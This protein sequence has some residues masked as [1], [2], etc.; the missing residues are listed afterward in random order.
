MC[1][2]IIAVFSL[3]DWKRRW[4]LPLTTL[5]VYGG[6]SLAF[7]LSSNG[8]YAYYCYDLLL[9]QQDNWMGYT[10]FDFVKD[11]VLP[12]LS[13]AALFSLFVFL[14]WS[15]RES[16]ERLF[17]WLIIFAST[18]ITSYVGKSKVGGVN[19]VVIPTFAIFSLFLGIGVPEILKVFQTLPKRSH[20]F[21]EICL[22]LLVFFQLVQVIY[23]PIL[24][25][26]PLADYMDGVK[27]LKF[28]KKFDGNVYVPNSSILLMAGKQTFAH[29]YAIWEIVHSHGKSKEKE[30]FEIDLQR[31]IDMHLFD[32]IVVLP[33]L[34]YFPDLSKYYVLDEAK[35]LLVDDNFKEK[36]DIYILP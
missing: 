4:A 9:S 6:I 20:V 30:A 12:N 15:F 21:V 13:I 26:P 16:K 34:D 19:N 18:V 25:V 28:V 7:I 10:F 24:Q 14:A 17:L 23:N 31:A 3:L 36:G 27:A 29:P 33:S 22:C 35:Y 8:W 1:L 5:L 32:A 11:Y 2:P